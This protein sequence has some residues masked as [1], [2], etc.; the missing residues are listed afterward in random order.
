M[1]R[2]LFIDEYE[3]RAGEICSALVLAG[4]QVAALPPS[5]LD[6]A[7]RIKEIQP[8]I[9]LIQTEAPSRDTLEHLAVAHE[10]LPRPVVMFA[11]KSD[12]RMIRKVLRAGVSAYI[13]DGLSPQRLAPIMDVAIARFDQY[14]E[15]RQ[16]RDA[17]TQK[18]ADRVV[19]D[20]AKGL[21]MKAR[22]LDE[23]AAFKTL[24]KLA[25]DR[26]KSLGTVAGDLVR[27]KSRRGVMSVR[28][29]ASST[30]RPAQ[31]YLAMHWGG[32]YMKGLG[33][34]AM[35]APV[36]DP[37]S[38]QPELKHAAVQVEKIA[39]GWQLVAM[40]CD[41]G[42][43][44]HAAL[45]PWLNRFDYASLTLAG[46]EST[47]VVLHAWG[48]ADSAAPT[49]EF[50]A[51]L[52]AALDLNGPQMLDFSDARRGVAKRALI[53]NDRLLG[54]LLCKET[55]ATDWLFDLIVRGGST[56]E[57]RKWLFAPLAAPPN[58]DIKRGRVICNCFDVGEDE[59][60]AGF[61][62]GLDLVVL[63][64]RHQC[65]TACGSCLPEL[66][67]MEAQGRAAA[68]LKANAR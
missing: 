66:R 63:Q 8:D 50:L 24:R 15:L 57:L 31:T 46:R 37:V 27:I 7:D 1:L 6:L 5:C 33:V 49:P 53:E 61:A 10:T 26:G 30:L 60:L 51:E 55:R 38:R 28:A 47:V 4:H 39:T 35:M 59:I 44:L 22:G 3:S 19:I 25:M 43:Q 9:I 20:K 16:E 2:V 41:A 42:G 40:R 29:A 54:A 62:A 65:G 32:Q 12:A 64:G 56:R 45:Q 18:L 34:N 36:T 52:A 11:K 68:P 17:A 21:L 13:V 23:D 67:R 58:A 14:H 48:F